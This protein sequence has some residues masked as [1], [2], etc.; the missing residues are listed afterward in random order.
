[1]STLNTKSFQFSKPAPVFD[2]FV[3]RL[4]TWVKTEG[5]RSRPRQEMCRYGKNRDFLEAKDILN[6]FRS[7][8]P[9]K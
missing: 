4:R 3:L 5:V 6:S 7:V 2:H 9:G 8:D 1:M